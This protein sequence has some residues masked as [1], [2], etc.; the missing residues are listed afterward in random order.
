[1]SICGKTNLIIK[2]NFLPPDI[3]SANYKKKKQFWVTNYGIHLI[4]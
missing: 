1:M 3:G 2:H 4:N